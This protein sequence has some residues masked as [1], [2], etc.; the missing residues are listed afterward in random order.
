M[1]LSQVRFAFVLLL[2]VASASGCGFVNRIRAKN[3]LNEGAQAYRQGRFAEAQKKFELALQ[4]DPEQKNAPVFI[5]RSIQQQ[6]RPGVDTLENT[7]KA[8]DAIEAYK[9][10]INS[11][12]VDEKTKEDA[13]NSVAYLYR[14]LKDEDKE[15]AWL[16]QRASLESAPKEKRSDAF[17]VLASKQWNC[18]YEI[19]EQ[20]ENKKTIQKPDAVVIEYV[21]PKN[22]ADFDKARACALK[23]LELTEQAI[24]LNPNNP[25][26]WSYKTNLLR[27][28][29]KMAQM[30]GKNDEKA[31]YDRQADEAEQRQKQL[32]EEAER[33]KAEE[34]AKSPT[35]RAG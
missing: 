6:Y 28:M 2:I 11:D 12:Q 7:A 14:Q 5:A 3:A 19:T 1:K 20:K 33:R 15:T 8:N 18:S 25:S 21:K 9:R 4:L 13:Y 26:A 35:P 27:E 34:A 32:N 22:Q 10:V 17:T 30:E 23:G 16:M 29:S 31:N 24:S